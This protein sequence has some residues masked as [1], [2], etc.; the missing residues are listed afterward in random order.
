MATIERRKVLR[1]GLAGVCA[2]AG[3]PSFAATSGSRSL[4]FE[5][6]HTGEQAS[7]PYWENG[8]Y[9]PTAL[10][11]LDHLL[12][13]HRTNEVMKIDRDLFDQL[14][15]LQASVENPRPFQIISGY[16]SPQ[17]NAMLARRSGGVSKR[18][19][20]Q[21]GMAIDVRLPG[22]RLRVLRQAALSMK[23]GG[24]GYYPRSGFIHLDTGRKRFW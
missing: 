24:V 8:V 1:L 11:A 21:F 20:H 18:S 9:I 2:L 14:H 5:N 15:H 3:G 13:D 7:I 4:S 17:T 16:R 10:K 19:Y 23:A 12:R 22:T 6:L